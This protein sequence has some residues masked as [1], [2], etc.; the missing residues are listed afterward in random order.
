M[1]RSNGRCGGSPERP[2]KDTAG[3]PAEGQLELSNKVR[4]EGPTRAP[5]DKLTGPPRHSA[6]RPIG[7]PNL[8]P[9]QLRG[10]G[11]GIAFVLGIGSGEVVVS[12]EGRSGAEKE[13]VFEL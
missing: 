3:N 9:V 7:L 2:A 10:I 8:P 1:L 6:E 12:V 5:Q 11:P 4:Q 13:V